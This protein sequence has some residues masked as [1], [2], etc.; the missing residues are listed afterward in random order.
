MLNKI[1][2][3]DLTKRN[4]NQLILDRKAAFEYLGGLGLASRY[5][6]ENITPAVNP[7]SPQAVLALFTSVLED[8]FMG[9]R[10]FGV[11]FKSPLTGI[12]GET[13][14]N[15]SV[16]ES[17]KNLGYIGIVIQ[18][19]SDQPTWLLIN[20]SDVIFHD[21][22]SLWGADAASTCIEIRKEVKSKNLGVLS[23][24]PA[25]ENLVRYASIIVDGK[26]M[27]P[28]CGGGA[29]MGSKNLKAIA[30]DNPISESENENKIKEAGLIIDRIRS[31]QM[32][33][34]RIALTGDLALIELANER[35]VFP[36][37]YWRYGVSDNYLNFN[38]SK[39]ASSILEE[40]E[41]CGDCPIKCRFICRDPSGKLGEKYHLTY[42]TVNAFAG[43]CGLVNVEDIACMNGLCYRLGV[44]PASLGNM[45]SFA[46]ELAS[47]RKLK[48][49]HA[50]DYGDLEGIKRLAEQICYRGEFGFYFSDGLRIAAKK[51][52]YSGPLI[53]IKGLEPIGLDPRGLNLYPLL[54]GVSESGGSHGSL[55]LFSEE[56]KSGF[57][58]Y[59]RRFDISEVIELTHKICLIN[60]LMLCDVISPYLDLPLISDMVTTIL[61]IQYSTTT[62]KIIS[63]KIIRLNRSFL[64][65][66]GLRKK[67]D[68]L[69]EIFYE[70]PLL[71]GV[72]KGKVLDYDK[73]VN[74]LEE[75][76][77]RL[78]LDKEWSSTKKGNF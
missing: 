46:I 63:E 39:I 2:V 4:Y 30:V 11:F 26:Y 74:K 24:G 36:T 34:D 66:E 13:Y 53:E 57:D 77:S 41:G 27:A 56:L 54:L 7:F 31:A 28:R 40:R 15:G 44:D 22:N 71:T 62:L 23:I 20:E 43:L 58:K 78:A 6:Y 1:L 8:K 47:K 59:L 18:G 67:D 65:R 38:A 35:G 5:L 29:V 70:Q 73:F 61:G 42:E 19:S 37:R 12:V 32:E 51:L 64:A 17:L 14:V 60:T 50:I 48:K 33:K 69:P 45:I 72:S 52:S 10:R 76:Y 75:Y 49:D 3:V 16:S 25:G 55:S 9:S 68:I 21:A